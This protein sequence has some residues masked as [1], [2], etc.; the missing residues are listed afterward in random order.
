MYSVYRCLGRL[1]DRVT[2]TMRT[3]AEASQ[4]AARLEEREKNENVTYCV[5]GPGIAAVMHPPDGPAGSTSKGMRTVKRAVDERSKDIAL[6][7]F[8][9]EELGLGIP[10]QWGKGRRSRKGWYIP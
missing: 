1:E 5:R 6:A 2:G 9:E 8:D 3:H 7:H 10:A 4:L